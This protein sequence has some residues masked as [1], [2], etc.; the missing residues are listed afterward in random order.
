MIE[1]FLPPRARALLRDPLPWVL[2]VYLSGIA[3]RVIYTLH[4]QRPEDLILSDMDF[5]V[6]LARKIAAHDQLGPWEATH[7]L[8]YP[9][10]LAFLISGAGS[11]T[12]AVHA[13]IVISALVPPAVGLLGGVAYGR[14]TGLLATVFASLYFPFIDYGALFLAEIPFI[15]SLT[16]AFAALLAARNVRRRGVSLGLAAAGG[17]ALSVAATLKSVAL[18]A[19][20]VFFV[21][22]GVALL[23]ARPDGAPSW[24]ARLTPWLVR[25]VVVACAAAPLL[26]GLARACTRANDGHFCVAGNKSG[27]DFFLGHTGRVANVAW[28]TPTRGI[29]YGSPG[30][31]LRHY[32][33]NVT[34]T[35]AIHDNA[36]NVAAAWDWIAAHP[37]QAI[38]L[39]LD[40]IYDVLFGVAAWP[41]Y[42]NETWL[43]AHLSQYLFIVLLFVPA[44]LAWSGIAR[45]GLRAAMTSRTALMVAPI[46]ALLVTV[47][48]ATGEVRYR[49]PFD[50]FFIAIACAFFTGDLARID[51][52]P[53][54]PSERA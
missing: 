54:S 25:G 41:T 7:P 1:R 18:P 52:A 9:T 28:E 23:L 14:R 33:G 16:L 30:S 11:L 10:L 51:G 53:V 32:D 26:G 44:V 22:E 6:V 48:I 36:A 19:A 47:A 31:F 39:S 17:F 5:Y 12:R 29:A 34:V 50:V 49:I 46:A 4:I 24:R 35:F 8:G 43:W 15:L 21:V 20:V 2:L 40:H 38:V 27:A 13:Q 3:L 37:G 42:G 45:R